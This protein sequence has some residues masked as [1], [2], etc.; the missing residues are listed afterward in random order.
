[1][2]SLNGNQRDRIKGEGFPMVVEPRESIGGSVKKCE[3]WSIESGWGG[4]EIR[5]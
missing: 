5:I 3:E 2:E 4:A 1:M